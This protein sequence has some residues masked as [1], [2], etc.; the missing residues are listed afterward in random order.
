MFFAPLKSRYRAKIRNMGVPKTS[1]H[2]QIIIRMQTPT[3]EPPA[4][5]KAPNQDLNDMDVLCT[6]KMK[7]NSQNY[8]NKSLLEPIKAELSL[9]QLFILILKVQR[10]SMSF[11]SWYGA[12]EGTG[13]SWLGFCILIMIWIWSLVFGTPICQI[14]ALYLDFEGAKNI[15]VL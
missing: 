2:I 11:K 7:I 1:D 4:Y 3:Q 15:H 5:S 6:Y 13:G 10:T 9:F 12:L 14:L 8:S